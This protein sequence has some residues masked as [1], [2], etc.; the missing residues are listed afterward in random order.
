MT[1][2]SERLKERRIRRRTFSNGFIFDLLSI[3]IVSKKS[4]GAVVAMLSPQATAIDLVCLLK[5]YIGESKVFLNTSFVEFS[6][7][8]FALLHV[9]R[10]TEEEERVALSVSADSAP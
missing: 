8:Q 10:R 1:D 2:P 4:E 5:E 3:Q 6:S 9:Q 7:S